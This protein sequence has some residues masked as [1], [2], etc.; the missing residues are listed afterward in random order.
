MSLEERVPQV[1]GSVG[2]TVDEA[3]LRK[4]G[5]RPGSRIALL[6]APEEFARAFL[7]ASPAT[8]LRV[9]ERDSS[10]FDLV[11]VWIREARDLEALFRRLQGMVQPDGAVWA[12]IRKKKG[13]Q[14]SSAQVTFPQVQE[15]GLTTDLVDN[16]DLSYSAE[17]YGV[18]FV[19][20][21][22][23]RRPLSREG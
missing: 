15:A 18:R 17:E 7:A 4:L 9:D 2:Y 20:R 5:A 21:R 8:L 1:G 10:S 13:R 6:E 3:F 19:V 23:R 16:K 12:V 22:E 14:S 11:L